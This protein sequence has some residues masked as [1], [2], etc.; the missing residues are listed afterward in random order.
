[1]EKVEETEEE[2]RWEEWE[3]RHKTVQLLSNCPTTKYPSHHQFYQL[4]LQLYHGKLI[5]KSINLA[6]SRALDIEG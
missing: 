1:M 5:I 6:E 2:E 4:Q 3:E